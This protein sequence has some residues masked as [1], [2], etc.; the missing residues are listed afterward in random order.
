M[1]LLAGDIRFARSA[2]MADVPEGGG[3][4]S[5][6]LLTSGRSNEIF[7]DISEETRTVGRV[8]IYQI[9]GVLRNTDR[10]ALLGSN[11]IVAQP[12]ADPNVGITLLTLKNPFATRADIARRIEG[13]MGAASE[14]SGYL[15]ESHFATMRAVQL[16]QRPGMPAPTVGKTYVLVYQEGTPAERRQRIRIKTV[17]TQTRPYTELVGGQLLDFE[18]QVSTCEI[19]DG[20]L[21]DFPGSPPSRYFGRDTAKTMVRET[22]YTDSG[23]FYS[24]SALTAP[25]AAPDTWLQ[26]ASVYT[27]IV[28]NS[29]T[30]AASTD[31]K[32]AAQRALVLADAPRRVEVGI[33]PHSQRVRI[34]EENLG[35][36]FVLQCTPLPAPGT[37]VVSYRAMGNWY[38]LADDG[39]GA[40]A[41]SGAGSVNYGTGTVS[42]TLAA[43]P[44]V[45]SSI[46]TQWGERTAYASR[47]GAAGYRMPE[48]AWELPQKPVKPGTIAVSWQSGGVTKTATDSGTGE[49][50]GDG[51]GAVNYATGQISL[52]PS[53]MIDAGG[54]LSTAYTYTPQVTERFD[55]V[56]PDAGGFTTLTLGE[57]P[58]PRSVNVRWTTV[59]NCTASAGSTEAV[60]NRTTTAGV[61][62]DGVVLYIGGSSNCGVTF[63]SPTSASTS[64]FPPGATVEI[65]LEAS[66]QE[67]FT[68]QIQDVNTTPWKTAALPAD[69]ITGASSGTVA[70][71]FPPGI[72][73]GRAFG[74]FTVTLAGA[75][76]MHEGLV[77]FKNSSLTTVAFGMLRVEPSSAVRAQVN[78]PAPA[79]VARTPTGVSAGP[80]SHH[81]G[82]YNSTDGTVFGHR[83]DV[84]VAP[85]Y[86]ATYGYSYDPPGGQDIWGDADMTARQKTMLSRRGVSTTYKRWGV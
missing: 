67:T 3:P 37:V 56:A 2:N 10:A 32:P 30:E 8:E 42:I 19:F 24:A 76:Q 62:P 58:A 71:V 66:T 45:G 79:D 69:L 27:Q 29:R 1:P 20:L 52:R 22:V 5:A 23:M 60:T 7:P 83:V 40:L 15:L 47:A 35:T 25:C 61:G 6:Q 18:A 36:V 4:P 17:D 72:V 74:K 46:I 26:L 41:G 55:G 70:T 78:P 75:A 77:A 28:P 43:I 50:S 12:P 13:G 86:D 64:G 49:L 73:A 54:E 57:V 11:I 81:G 84:S 31:R 68:W 14:W 63:Y 44:D 51:A 33:T 21:Y 59:R 80:K 39:A 85:L 65:T 16:L 9:F 48:F 82:F 53:H 38:T 34:L